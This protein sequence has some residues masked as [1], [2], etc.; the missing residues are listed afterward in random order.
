MGKIVKRIFDV[1]FIGLIIL[2]SCYFIFRNMGIIE[3]YQ[4]ET[5][6]MESGIHVGDYV[7]ICRK[8]RY[9]IGDIVT[10]KKSDY[11][12]THRIIKSIQGNKV[13]TKGDANN[14]ADEEID[15]DAIVGKVIYIGGLLN[16]VINYKYGIVSFMLGLYLLSC[17]SVKKGDKVEEKEDKTC[18]HEDVVQVMSP[19]GNKE[20]KGSVEVRKKIRKRIRPKYRKK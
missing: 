6:S 11:F 3:I 7:L 2:L 4:V 13:I 10:Y 17:Y 8:D 9:V 19:E 5:G 15:M 18:E 20:V 16:I 12:I 14:T 1:L